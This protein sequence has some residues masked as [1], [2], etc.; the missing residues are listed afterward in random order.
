MFVVRTNGVVTGVSVSPQFDGQEQMPDDAP[1]VVA[2]VKAL[3]TSP[4]QSVTPLQM[5]RALRRLGLIDAVNAYVQSQSVDVQ[6][7]WQYCIGFPRNDP[8][9]AA[10]GQALNVD[11]DALFDLAATFP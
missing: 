11:L 3:P 10:A 2:C 6:D 4:I 8:M 9:I 5:R 7:S 1:E